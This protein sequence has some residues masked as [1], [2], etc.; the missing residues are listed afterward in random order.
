MKRYLK[1]IVQAILNKPMHTYNAEK[2][3]VLS[4]ASNG[5]LEG[6]VAIVT[7]GSGVLGRA[8]CLMLASEGAMVYVAGRRK[9]RLDKIIQEINEMS[10]NAKPI[11]MDVMSEQSIK[12][13]INTIYENEDHIDILVNCAGGSSRE[14][15]APLVSQSMDIVNSIIDSNLKGT[16]MCSKYT[17]EKMIKKSSG[18]IINIASTT[19][20]QGNHSNCDYTAAKSGVIGFTKALAQELGL[21]G[22]NVNCVSP[23]FIQTGIFD[24]ER[25]E[26]LERTN[27]LRKVGSPEDIAN[28]V[29]FLAS[30]K[31]GFITGINL[32]IDGGR[33]L[34]LHTFNS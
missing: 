20:I 26:Y 21:Y 6:K 9:D 18:K 19:G 17:A 4:S 16:I 30:D 1:R 23:G 10:C 14:N 15:M 22:I 31:A 27:F 33:I 13:N 8:I 3:Y 12:E 2:N 29:C 25:V 5:T 32:V 7:G 34:G 11:V 28:G 24:D